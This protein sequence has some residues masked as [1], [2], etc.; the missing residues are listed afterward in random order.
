A[1]SVDVAHQG[2]VTEEQERTH[3]EAAIPPGLQLC[4]QHHTM[5][6]LAVD[7]PLPAVDRL[8]VLRNGVELLPP[9]VGRGQVAPVRYDGCVLHGNELD[10]QSLLLEMLLELPEVPVF[11]A[12]RFLS[13]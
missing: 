12:R 1:P 4:I 8:R 3:P 2:A 11:H 6:P 9:L 10:L 13:R 7:R 5:L